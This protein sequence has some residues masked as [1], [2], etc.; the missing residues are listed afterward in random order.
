MALRGIRR[1]KILA[2]ADEGFSSEPR[3]RDMTYS[4]QRYDVRL[5]EQWWIVLRAMKNSSQSH[6]G[7]LSEPE[8]FISRWNKCQQ[9]QKF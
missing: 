6:E 1:G 3:L 9:Q 8:I 7:L 2:P 5:S 4:S